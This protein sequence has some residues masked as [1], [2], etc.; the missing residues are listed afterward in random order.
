MGHSPNERNGKW[1]KNVVK[2]NKTVEWGK[3]CYGRG[4]VE[5][6]GSFKNKILNYIVKEKQ[7]RDNM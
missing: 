7:V 6:K 2:E 5:G 4:Y 3:P 1:G